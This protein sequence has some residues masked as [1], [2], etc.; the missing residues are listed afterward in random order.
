M[1]QYPIRGECQCGSIRYEVNGPFIEQVACHCTH[2]QKFSA[3]AFG[4]SALIARENFT[5]ISGE[6][7]L[8][9]RT[10]DSGNRN[11]CYFCAECGN[12][13]YHV[14]P[15]NAGVLRLK[16]GTLEDTS[17]INPTVHYWVKR[18]QAWV[19][20][21]EGVQCYDTQPKM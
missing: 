4:V 8:F 12:R 19:V 18:K 10:A 11:E 20:I 6:L 14:N 9:V 2:C 5:L 17:A 13:I 3:T 16:P 21:P 1:S 7:K 15:N